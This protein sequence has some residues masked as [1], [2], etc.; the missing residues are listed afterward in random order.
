MQLL[1]NLDKSTICSTEWFLHQTA[2]VFILYTTERDMMASQSHL[3]SSISGVP[4][5]TFKVIVIGDMSVGKTS[6]VC[7]LCGGKF[8]EQIETTIG[9]DFFEKSMEVESEIVKVCHSFIFPFL[10]LAYNILRLVYIMLWPGK[11]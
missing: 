2:L 7:R 3:K 1:K 6:L 10:K 11:I 9:V 4:A 8:S 5:R